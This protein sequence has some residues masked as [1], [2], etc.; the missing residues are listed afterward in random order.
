MSPHVQT[1]LKT[2]THTTSIETLHVL[3]K[4][5]EGCA[6]FAIHVELISYW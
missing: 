6:I 1:K 2:H 3:I 5:T 4:R